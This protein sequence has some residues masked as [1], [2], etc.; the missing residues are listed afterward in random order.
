MHI[1]SAPK[2][3]RTLTWMLALSSLV[4]LRIVGFPATAKD[5]ARDSPAAI[6]CEV[7]YHFRERVERAAPGEKEYSAPSYE[8][9]ALAGGRVAHLPYR[10][11]VTLGEKKPVMLEVNILDGQGKSLAGYPKTVA[12]TYDPANPTTQEFDIPVGPKLA[13]RIEKRVLSKHQELTQVQLVVLPPQ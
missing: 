3:Y 10:F 5:D 6:R 2:A 8:K 9:E 1:A 7:R 13:R 4:L 12:Y 11:K